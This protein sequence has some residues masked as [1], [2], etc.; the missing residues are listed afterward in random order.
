MKNKKNEV[1]SERLGRG[2]IT[3]I[4][5]G[6]IATA[7]MLSLAM[8][9]PNAVQALS[10]FGVGKKKYKVSSYIKTTAG[11]LE[12]AGLVKFERNG[13][14]VFLKLTERG[15]EKLEKDQIFAPRSDEVPN[16]WDGKW[17]LVVFD[18][19]ESTR[20]HRD[21]LRIWLTDIGFVRIQN[22]VWVYPYDREEFIFLLKT[23]F[24][25][26][27]SVLFATVEKLENDGWLR[28]K[29]GLREL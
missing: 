1:E 5:L 3:N 15:Q 20:N 6:C 29:F 17:R 26:G 16:N 18:I 10:L 11:K 27:K 8:L 13:D 9:A 14:S 23:D 19:K 25:L 4:I 2:Q 21:Q 22:S 12:K 28:K 7:G 24:E